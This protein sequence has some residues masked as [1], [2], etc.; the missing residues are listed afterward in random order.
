[1]AHV[2]DKTRRVDPVGL[3]TLIGVGLIILGEIIG[4]I[5][6]FRE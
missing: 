5:I 1:M 3:A 6:Y 4:L 2:K